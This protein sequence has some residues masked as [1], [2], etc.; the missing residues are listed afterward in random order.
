MSAPTEG[1]GTKLVFV[2]D[3]GVGKTCII[4]RF[5]KGSF[6]ADVAST[7]GAN[8]I[9]KTIEVPEL[10]E[11]LD[12]DIWDTAGQEKYKSLTRIFFKGA[13]LAVLVYDITRNDTFE[14]M[15]NVW[16]KEI[17]EHADEDIIIGIAGNKSDLYDEEKVPE[18]EARAFAK[19][20][21]AVFS[22]TSAQNNSGINDLFK[23]LVKKYL[24]P[25]ASDSTNSPSDDKK[26]EQNQELPA[27]KPG[28]KPDKKPD[29]KPSPNQQQRQNQQ[30]NIKLGI[31]D[32]KK[33]QKKKFC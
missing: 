7:M 28:K 23:N 16:L 32:A 21:G 6:E 27:E 17:K 31:E 13:K 8:Y 4:S 11:S 9:S 15:K 5:I 1:K 10:G 29:K 24:D 19:S 14:N 18:E 2:G 12:L 3:P 26:P 30:N 20:I 25:N 22:L 33:E